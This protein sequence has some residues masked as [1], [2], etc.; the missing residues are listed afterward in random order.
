MSASALA[1]LC[2]GLGSALAPLRVA[3]HPEQVGVLFADLGLGLPQQVLD[4]ADWRAAVGAARDTAA[5][6]SD[7][8]REL[9]AAITNDNTAAVTLHTTALVERLGMLSGRL[10][11]IADRLTA[12]AAMIPG[13]AAGEVT[14]FATRLPTCVLELMAISHLER[15][16]PG[17]CNALTL[18]G[19]VDRHRDPGVPG[20]PTRPAFVVRRLRLDR[21]GSL[22]GS[23]GVYLTS[24]YGWNTLAFDGRVLL[25]A[26]AEAGTLAAL[27]AV[28]ADTATGPLLDLLG[29]TVTVDTTTS[30]PGLG[31]VLR[32]AIPA[33]LSY[34]PPLALPGGSVRL[35]TGPELP[36]GLSVQL[37]PPGKL[38]LTPPAGGPAVTGTV[39]AEA[40]IGTAPPQT[41]VVL[42]GEA[43]QTRL[44]AASVSASARAEFVQ[45]AAAG[46]ARAEPALELAI[47]GGRFMLQ[48]GGASN[49][50]K[51]L[52]QKDAVQADFDLAV[53]WSDGRIYVRGGAALKADL[54]VHLS[55]GPV[56]VQTVTVALTPGAGGNLPVELSATLL[57]RFGPLALLVERVGLTAELAFPADGGNA[58]PLDV[59]YGFKV[60][61]GI[62]ASLDAGPVT[63]GGYLLFDPPANRF[64][65][66][67]R[68]KLAFLEATAY[69]IYEQ[70]GDHPSFVAV[71]GIRFTRAS[72][73]GSASH[74]PVSAG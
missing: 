59:T 4:D 10:T 40:V 65:G 27:P 25:A 68:L 1:L 35:V 56:D 72:S 42:L 22:L 30:P 13:V 12:L 24:L 70:A 48:F 49:L 14:A 53:R 58:G 20:N 36:A 71:L 16:K 23:P 5:D 37:V 9:S 74:S 8:T 28:L 2:R 17:V 45:D 39:S 34:E 60:P 38:L 21:L 32:F 31:G 33:G 50:L 62:G 52:I 57:A 47:Q 67:L 7:V 73:S 3:L 43:G 29:G 19:L 63:G 46:S 69:G 64:G 26:L 44:E 11:A 54:P 61:T 15:T 66:A 18:C 55:L 51:T 6:L 41:S